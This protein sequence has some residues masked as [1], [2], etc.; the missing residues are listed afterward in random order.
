MAKRTNRFKISC[1]DSEDERLEKLADQAGIPKARY[2]REVALGKREQSGL[3]GEGQNQG[4]G[5][6]TSLVKETLKELGAQGDN[7]NQIAKYLN[8]FGEVSKA[9]FNECMKRNKELYEKA[10]KIYNR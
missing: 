4:R 5:I 6:P 3:D 9:R 10:F 1:T 7:L 8:T 2:V